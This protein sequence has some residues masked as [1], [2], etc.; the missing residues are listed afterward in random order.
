MIL[1][2]DVSE[3]QGEMDWPKCKAA[4]AEFAYFRVGNGPDSEDDQFER[5]RELAPVVLP[6]GGYWAFSPD[7]PALEQADCFCDYLA[8]WDWKLRPWLDIELTGTVPIIERTQ[9]LENFVLRVIQRLH[10]LP[11]IYTRAIWFRDHILPN[12]VWNC[13]DL[14]VARYCG[15]DHPWGDGECKPRDWDDFLFWQWS[16]DGN[17]RGAEFGAESDSIDLDWYQGALPGMLAKVTVNR[18]AWLRSAARANASQVASTWGGRAFDV[19][20]K[21]LDWV[22][23]AAWIKRSDV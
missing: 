22:K 8:T 5:N 21:R 17:N 11:I 10:I 4:G 23:V 1:G 13:C 2:V 12:M 20:E 9:A 3:Y 15:L 18:P 16:A 6:T 19:V 14:A 7:W